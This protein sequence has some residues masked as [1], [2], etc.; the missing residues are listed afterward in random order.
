MP[1]ESRP[2]PSTLQLA[3]DVDID[4]LERVPAVLDRDDADDSSV[5]LGDEDLLP[6]DPIRVLPHRG[7]GR[8]VRPARLGTGRPEP[9]VL[10][11]GRI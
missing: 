4:Q 6:A 8:D 3:R 2:D 5:H 9:R 7:Q 10:V 1:N 11:Y